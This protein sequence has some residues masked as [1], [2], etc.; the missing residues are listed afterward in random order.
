TAF[1]AG[2]A[3]RIAQRADGSA[4][5]TFVDPGSDTLPARVMLSTRSPGGGFST[6]VAV[7][8][9]SDPV[10][11]TASTFLADG[12][13]VIVW[14]RGGRVFAALRPPGGQFGAATPLSVAGTPQANGLALAGGPA[15]DA[16]AM[17][18]LAGS[19]VDESGHTHARIQAS[20]LGGNGGVQQP[21]SC[22]DGSVQRTP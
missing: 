9:G 18:S 11:A 21:P 8:S 1:A 3:P 4:A 17:W 19:S 20:Q 14:I 16:V 7:D 5:L 12:T 10:T 22:R 2:T 13:L 15:G 6:P